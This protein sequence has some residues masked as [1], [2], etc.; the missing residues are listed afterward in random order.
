MKTKSTLDIWL[1]RLKEEP[2]S[3]EHFRTPSEHGQGYDHIAVVVTKEGACFVGMAELSKKDNYNRKL[4]FMISVGRAC[5][6]ICDSYNPHSEFYRG[7]D[8]FVDPELRGLR[9]RDK[10]WGSLLLFKGIKPTWR[11]FVRENS[12]PSRRV[13]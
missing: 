2:L 3:V 12:L 4:G 13:L 1:P 10:V 8:F 5:K 11:D 7:P 6:I 9:L